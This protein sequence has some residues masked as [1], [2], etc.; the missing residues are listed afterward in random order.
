MQLC[1]RGRDTNDHFN[2]LQCEWK[3]LHMLHLT[4]HERMDPEMKK[5]QYTTGRENVHACVHGF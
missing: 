1:S 4:Q 3:L 5:K 2:C